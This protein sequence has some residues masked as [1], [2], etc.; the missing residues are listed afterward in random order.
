MQRN[1]NNWNKK[2][3]QEINRED[4]ATVHWKLLSYSAGI[5]MR[6]PQTC[7]GRVGNHRFTR[8]IHC[9]LLQYFTVE[10]KMHV[11][12]SL[13]CIQSIL[14]DWRGADRRP[15]VF[16]QEKKKQKQEINEWSRHLSFVYPECLLG[17]RKNV[18]PYRV[19]TNLL[20]F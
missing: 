5:K 14:C 10:S 17:W 6:A 20:W 11:Q 3:P 8:C 7:T 4:P 12:D 9:L 18:V 19:V 2:Q 15:T 16:S 13:E 1:I